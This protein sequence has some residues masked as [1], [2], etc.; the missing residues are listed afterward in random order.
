LLAVPVVGV[1]LS[2]I[3]LGEMLSVPLLLAMALILKLRLSIA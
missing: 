2:T 3:G 1:A